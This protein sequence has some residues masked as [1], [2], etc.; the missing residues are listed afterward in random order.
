MNDFI[1]NLT[2]FQKIVGGLSTLLVLVVFLI[3]FGWNANGVFGETIDVPS[4]L[5]TIDTT[6]TIGFAAITESI[7]TIV[8]T[9]KNHD[10][11]L[12]LQKGAMCDNA[13][14]PAEPGE[15]FARQLYCARL[16]E[17]R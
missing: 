17:I 13:A 8:S 10:R 6:I 9:L 4:R 2:K 15:R 5:N 12:E 11:Q 16:D 7:D 14:L 3:T 1:N